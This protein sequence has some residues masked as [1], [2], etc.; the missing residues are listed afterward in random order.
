MMAIDAPP[1]DRDILL[2]FETP[3]EN[4]M[5]RGVSGFTLLAVVA[6]IWAGAR[7]ER[8]AYSHAGET[9]T[10]STAAQSSCLA[11]SPK[12]LSP[13]LSTLF[14]P[15]PSFAESVPNCAA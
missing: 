9:D 4:L 7:Q 1:G 3:V 12:D 6:L 15:R 2:T 14:S 11:T 5:G 10:P 8:A 13:S